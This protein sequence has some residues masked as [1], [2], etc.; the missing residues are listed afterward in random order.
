MLGTADACNF[1]PWHIGAFQEAAWLH[2]TGK[3]F[4]YSVHFLLGNKVSEHKLRV[5][6]FFPPKRD[7]MVGSSYIGSQ[8]VKHVT[9]LE[10]YS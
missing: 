2:V 7:V 5:S 4:I 6:T 9:S 3:L 8:Y 1:S 10:V